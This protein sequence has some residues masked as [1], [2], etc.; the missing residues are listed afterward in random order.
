[1]GLSI[2]RRP[3]REEKLVSQAEAEGSKQAAA[4][5]LVLTLA[6]LAIA[7]PACSR[8]QAYYIKRGNLLARDRNDR[9]AL[10]EYYKAL[11]RGK[12]SHRL[13]QLIGDTHARLGQNDPVQLDRAQANYLEAAKLARKWYEETIEEA[14]R[15]PTLMQKDELLMKL[16][17]TI[18]PYLSR[19]WVQVGLVYT[20]MNHDKNAIDALRLALHYVEDNLVARMELARLLERKRDYEAAMNEWLRFLKDAE[21]STAQKKALYGIGNAE[22]AIARRHFERLAEEM[23]D[24]LLKRDN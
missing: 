21:R 9:G 2:E 15:A 16:Q 10:V 13:Y 17:N 3:V 14:R 4:A 6:L 22:V 23:S 20:A 8:T 24:K 5:V 19:V 7:G 11:E 18:A 12:P 1:V